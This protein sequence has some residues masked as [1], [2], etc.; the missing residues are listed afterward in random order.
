MVR[1]RSIV[2]L[3][4]TATLL[5][6]PT[7]ANAQELSR[8]QVFELQFRLNQLGYDAGRID[9]QTGPRTRGAAYRFA[10]AHDTRVDL[11]PAFL[12]QVRAA[13]RSIEGIANEDGS[14]DLLVFSD[15]GTPLVITV[16]TIGALVDL[17]PAAAPGT[18]EPGLG[19]LPAQAIH[20]AAV[21]GGLFGV[22]VRVPGVPEG[23]RLSVTRIVSEPKRLADGTVRFTEHITE[24]VVMTGSQS[25][26]LLWAWE[27]NGA[28]GTEGSP[29]WRFTLENAG[30]ILLTR[31]FR[32]SAD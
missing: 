5:A 13:A 10:D 6:S 28:P 26:P 21:P 14:T 16:E 7:V 31:S 3:F 23:D 17:V 20:T 2:L 22:R 19:T 32:V 29:P 9:G 12:A 1:M 4:A 25:G 8:N 15:Q 30:D 24:H 11:N 18:L 27:V